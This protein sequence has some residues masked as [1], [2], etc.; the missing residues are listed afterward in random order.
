M[1]FHYKK[2]I[3]P[4]FYRAVKTETGFMYVAT[5]LAELAEKVDV[6][7]LCQY[8][9]QVFTHD[10]FPLLESG[11]AAQYQLEEAHDLVLQELIFMLD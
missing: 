9:D 1:Q 11:K 8:H 6:K 5:L 7:V 2:V 10:I 4:A 3:N